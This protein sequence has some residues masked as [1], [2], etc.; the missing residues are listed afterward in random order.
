MEIK[1]LLRTSRLPFLLLTPVCVFLGLSAALATQLQINNFF[2]VPVLL[3]AVSAHISVNMLNEYHDFKSGLDLKTKKTPFSGGSGALPAHPEMANL[4]L[5]TGL[6]FLLITVATGIYLVLW[7]G[8]QIMPIGIIGILIIFTY[9][10]FLN[11]IPVL[12]LIA[13]GFGFGVLIVTGT[14]VV[15]TGEYSRLVLLVSLAPFFLINNLLLL[16]QYP[17]IKADAS[18]G[19][20]TFP[21]A[22]GLT[23]SNAMYATFMIAAYSIILFLVMMEY[24]PLLGFI[25][26]IPV[27]FSAYTLAGAIKYS[28]KIGD[29]HQY[30][31][32]NVIAA[33]LTP[34]L[35]GIS[36]TYG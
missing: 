5:L 14:Y 9:T 31:V 32:T 33:I 28:S 6:G 3:G 10:K 11:R 2:V 27:L 4:V 25:A 35:L 34:L 23:A 15:L 18:V 36:I 8:L 13:P 19:R 17:D 22:Y 29:F 20:S 12:C 1:I 30:M 16:N 21:I 26:L 24:I 7:R